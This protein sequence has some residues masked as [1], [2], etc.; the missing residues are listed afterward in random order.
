M[1]QRPG[2]GPAAG[3]RRRR[4]A[5]FPWRVT[6]AFAFGGTLAL[7]GWFWAEGKAVASGLFVVPLLFLLTAPV[8]VRAS[9][10]ETRFDLAGIM[11]TGL[12]LRFAAAYYAF[13]HAADANVYNQFGTAL[14]RQFRA[15]HFDVNTGAPVPGTGGLRYLAG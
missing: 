9:R 12:A 13:D 4:E 15:L 14:A 11:A 5:T 7:Y 3:S 10:T 6:A 2:A 1:A 8:L